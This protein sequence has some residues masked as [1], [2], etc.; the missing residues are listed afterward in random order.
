MSDP[1]GDGP[2]HRY[3]VVPAAYVAL[4]REEAGAADSV[5]LQLRSGTGFMDGHWACGAAGHVE[6]GESVLDAAVR[7]ATEELGVRI[8]PTD[9]LPLTV[10][11]RTQGTGL[12]IDERVDFFLS[13]RRW[14]GEPRLREDKAAA[15]RWVRLD[16]LDSL[17]EPVVPHERQVLDALAAGTL[18]PVTTFGFAQH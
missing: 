2:V 10:M 13:C 6:A 3:R 5:L 16:A 14:H 8:A 11:H 18:M 7:E 17:R 1:S 9:L 12:A 4:L 15:L